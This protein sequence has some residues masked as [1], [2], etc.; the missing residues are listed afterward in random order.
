MS[1]FHHAVS[2]RG[3]GVELWILAGFFHANLIFV[4]F[5]VTAIAVWNIIGVFA[6]AEERVAVFFCHEA[7]GSEARACVPLQKI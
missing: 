1:F 5:R 7:F 4:E 6:L 2:N 3:H